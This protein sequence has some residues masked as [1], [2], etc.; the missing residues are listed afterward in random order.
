MVLDFLATAIH[1]SLCE[2]QSLGRQQDHR[3]QLCTYLLL[4]ET[5]EFIVTFGYKRLIPLWYYVQSI[6]LKYAGSSG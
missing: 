5:V 3:E 1:I 4:V 6:H 2:K